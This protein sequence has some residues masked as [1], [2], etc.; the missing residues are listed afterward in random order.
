MSNRGVTAGVSLSARFLLYFSIAYI[1]LIGLM[2]FV[3][4]RA[5]QSAMVENLQENL[6]VDASLVAAS[7]PDD[8]SQWNPWAEQAFDIGGFRVTVI[9]SNGAV[10]VDSHSD[11]EVMENHATRPEVIDAFAGQIGRASRVSASTGFEQ[12]YVALPPDDEGFIV[13]LSVSERAVQEQIAPVRAAVII[14]SLVVGLLGVVIVGWLA[15]RLTKPIVELTDQTMAIAAGDRTITP[16]RSNVRELDSL[17]LAISTLVDQLGSRLAE[18][19]QATETM[20][21]VLGA[22]PEGTILI[23]GDDSIIYANPAAYELIGAIPTELSGLA[24]LPFQ[25]AVRESRAGRIPVDRQTE[26]GNPVRLLKG[27]ATPFSDDERVLLIVVDVTE[28][29]RMATVRRDFVANASH[30]LKT[31]VSSILAS[32]EVLRIAVDKDREAAAR[33]AAQIEASALQL[34]RMVSDLLDLSRLER[35][36]PELERVSVSRIVREEVDRLREAAEDGGVGLEAATRPVEVMG[37]RRDLAIA[38]RNLLENALRHTPRDGHVVASVTERDGEAVIEI[39][40]TGEGIP[41][42]DLERVFER[43]YRVDA[44]RSRQSGGTGLGLSI[45]KHVVEGQRGTVEVE[46]ELGQGSTF[47]IRLPA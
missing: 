34:N 23:R 21:V 4:M 25:T 37:S 2:G 20:E 24:P 43:F 35:E 32:S 9:D 1:V 11:P 12:H 15:R 47:R 40:D 10:V 28:R 16:R 42:R 27:V 8:P 29:E 39:T 14:T 18:V 46:S 17:S 38:V 44:A 22:L 31:P 3:T 36:E 33:F 7:M 13:R 19:E 41:T 5:A 6:E 30:E 26:H 45:V